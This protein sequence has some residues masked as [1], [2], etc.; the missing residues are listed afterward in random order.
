M[1]E[2]CKGEGGTCAD[3]SGYQ[4]DC[5]WAITFNACCEYAEGQILKIIPACLSLYFFPQLSEDKRNF[6]G[7]LRSQSQ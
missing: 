1:P 4:T 3:L 6:G 7:S 2:G 5:N